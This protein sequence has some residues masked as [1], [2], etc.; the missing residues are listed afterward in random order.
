MLIIA[1]YSVSGMRSYY[2]CSKTPKLKKI[3]AL[4]FSDLSK[5]S[6]NERECGIRFVSLT[7]CL[8][9]DARHVNR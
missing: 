9:S 8:R 6:Q 5:T 1:A 7:N 3:T 2:F 4:N